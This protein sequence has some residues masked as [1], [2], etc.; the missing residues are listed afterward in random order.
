MVSLYVRAVSAAAAVLMAA[1]LQAPTAWAIDPPVIPADPLIP[2]DPPPAPD[3]AMQQREPC[4][5][6]GVLPTPPV[7]DIPPAQAMLNIDQAHKF[8]TG[9]GVTVAVIGTGVAPNPRL[10]RL[11][12]GGDYVA[13]TDGLVDCDMHETLVASIIG[14]QRAPGDQFVGVAPDVS[15]ISIRQSSTHFSP[16]RPERVPGQSPSQVEAAG[17]IDALAAAIVRAA[18]MGAKVINMSVV[19]CVPAAHPVDQSKLAIAVRYAAVVKDVL[20]VAAAGNVGAGNA[21]CQSNPGYDPL[22]PDDERN[23]AHVVSV[24]T[25]S[26]FADYVM[27]VAAVDTDGAAPDNANAAKFSMSG[28]WVDIAAPGVNTVALGPDGNPVNALPGRD[29]LVN[30]FGTSFSSAYVAGTA[31]LVRSKFPELSAAQVRRRLTQTAHAGPRGVD[32]S[33]GHG[34]IDP[35]AAL[36]YEMTDPGPREIVE[37]HRETLI[38]HPDPPPPD[39]RAHRWAL[40]ISA[41]VIVAVGV[42]ARII[43]SRRSSQ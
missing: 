35:V 26:W 20:L 19:A 6:P 2:D 1:T 41:M 27:S 39:T 10:P 37:T 29:G 11:Q 4:S 14:G 7:T 25:P 16:E 22:S 33:I 34:L 28:P 9:K 18:N 30:I 5:L 12:G 15:L 3:Q 21:D 17:K 23:W 31:A 36:T 40:A 42:A 8:S 24:S 43:F 38:V 32:N 13:D